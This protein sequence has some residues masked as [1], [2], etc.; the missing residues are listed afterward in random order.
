MCNKEFTRIY[1]RLKYK[2]RIIRTHQIS[3]SQSIFKY[4][5]WITAIQISE[6][7]NLDYL[8]TFVNLDTLVYTSEFALDVELKD[9]KCL[10]IKTLVVKQIDSNII[11]PNIV[12][13]PYLSDLIIPCL[14]SSQNL[15]FLC[16][17]KVTRL[18]VDAIVPSIL[19][20]IPFIS[21]T[22]ITYLKISFPLFSEDM[23]RI[24][25]LFPNL[26]QLDVSNAENNDPLN[27][28]K[29]DI[30][31]LHCDG[32]CI[33]PKS[34]KIAYFK[35]MFNSLMIP[36]NPLNLRYCYFHL[37]A[38]DHQNIKK[39]LFFLKND[40]KTF[41]IIDKVVVIS[42]QKEQNIL[43]DFVYRCIGIN[44]HVYVSKYSEY[45]SIVGQGYLKVCNETEKIKL[46]YHLF[47]YLKI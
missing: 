47:K 42:N 8:L 19:Q 18:T 30:Q 40:C 17:S 23:M 3:N 46:I 12:D 13:W 22:S 1:L 44:M 29:L 33:L 14:P 4:K 37:F 26:T 35:G 11:I 36:S 6:M 28:Y 2:G 38:S 7:M 27:F 9:L 5:D 45:H 20:D 24:S 25:K 32:L 41:L 21:L 39:C 43:R 10:K 31:E 34:V 15:Q 16:K